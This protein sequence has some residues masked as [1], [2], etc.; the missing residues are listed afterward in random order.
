[1]SL[2]LLSPPVLSERQIA[3]GLRQGSSESFRAL[4]GALGSPV[5]AYLSRMTGRREMAEELTQEVFLTAIRRIGF[6]SAG[7]DGSLKAWVFRIATNLAIDVLRRQKHVE[8][9]ELEAEVV[10]DGSLRGS[11]GSLS[12]LGPLDP[13]EEL[14]RFELTEAIERALLGLTASQRTIFLLKEQEGL[15]LLE[16]SRVCGLNENAI[17]QSLFRARAAL[18]KK[19][20]D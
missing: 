18:R 10:A 3:E 17:K 8:R 6:F 7:A 15:S 14:A 19:L 4:Y 2:V 11:S 13:E 5:L 1:L 16:I 12:P 20:C 9:V